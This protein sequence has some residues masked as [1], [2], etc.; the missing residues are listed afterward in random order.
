MW[1]PAVCEN[2]VPG[3]VAREDVT[4]PDRDAARK[5]EVLRCGDVFGAG[6][7]ITN[8][9]LVV[10]AGT[11][12]YDDEPIEGASLRRYCRQ[13]S[14]ELLRA[15]VRDE[16]AVYRRVVFRRSHGSCSSFRQLRQAAGLYMNMS[17]DGGRRGGASPAWRSTSNTYSA[18]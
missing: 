9:A 12:V 13:R 7:K 14:D 8:G 3:S 2:R 15:P 17:Q 18:G 4:H 1:K 11:V 5:T 16:D 6:N 10:G